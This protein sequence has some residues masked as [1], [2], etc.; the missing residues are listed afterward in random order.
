MKVTDLLRPAKRSRPDDIF[1]EPGQVLEL[2][3]PVPQ[4]APVTPLYRKPEDKPT[5]AELVASSRRAAAI[6]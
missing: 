6:V 5:P 3:I 2:P 4:A 1:A